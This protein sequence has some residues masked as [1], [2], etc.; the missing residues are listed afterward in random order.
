MQKT[1]TNT[2]ALDGVDN[3]TPVWLLPFWR[4][5]L[6]LGD[7]NHAWEQLPRQL[8]LGTVLPNVHDAAA[9]FHAHGLHRVKSQR[10]LRK[11]QRFEG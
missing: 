6:A 9:I 2:R 4:L 10:Q 8:P 3:V 11:F 5:V 7:Y 1:A